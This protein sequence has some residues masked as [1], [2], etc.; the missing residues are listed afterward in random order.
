MNIG[1]RVDSSNKIGTGHVNRCLTLADSL[2][3]KGFN[4]FFISRCDNGNINY[5]IRKAKFHICKL[6][7]KKITKLMDAKKTCEIIKKFKIK[8][9]VVDNYSIN[10]KWEMIVS[11]YCKIILINDF[12]KRKTFCDYFINYHK[13][14]LSKKENNL[15]INKNCKKFLGPRYSL[16]K[17]FIYNKNIKKEKNLIFVYMGGVDNNNTTMKTIDLLKSKEFL[18]FKIIVLIGEK[19]SKKKKIQL[20]VNSL[21]NFKLAPIKNKNLYNYFKK[22]SLS[23]INSGITMNENLSF[24][25]KSIIILQSNFHRKLFKTSIYIKLVNFVNSINNLKKDFILKI[26]NKSESL[27]LI[28][29]KKFYFDNKGAL[30]I[31]NYFSSICMAKKNI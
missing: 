25:G 16:V 20:V 13:V 30:R 21:K 17:K 15:L 1:F 27:K 5:K 24:G 23:I 29:R 26:L 31:S 19:N 6:G 14:S 18:N 28:K 3:I 12:L 10:F 22:A 8:Y 7:K 2:K 4:N 9:L 11:N